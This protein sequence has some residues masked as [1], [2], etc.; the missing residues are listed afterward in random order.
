MPAELLDQAAEGLPVGDLGVPGQVARLRGS[1][2]S[3]HKAGAV[4]AG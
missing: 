1:G 3:R 4:G 2:E